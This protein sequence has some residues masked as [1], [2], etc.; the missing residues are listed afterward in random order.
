M[1]E[2]LIKRLRPLAEKATPGEWF[3]ETYSSGHRQVC[4]DLRPVGDDEDAYTIVADVYKRE[5]HEYLV[6]VDPQAILTLLDAIEQQS[7]RLTAL[8]SERDE[9]I[10]ALAECRDAMPIPE[11]GSSL[12]G[13]WV[14]A[15]ASPL[16]VSGYI[17]EC[18]KTLKAE[19]FYRIAA[20][21]VSGGKS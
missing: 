14:S 11:A 13:H 3:P 20:Q 4:G 17:G 21:P 12:E 7:A 16:E 2:D 9:M 10:K 19:Q 5:D 6:A 15:I 8:E 18:Y 1:V